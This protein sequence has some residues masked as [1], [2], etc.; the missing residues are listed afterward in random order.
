MLAERAAAPERCC[1][2]T[3]RGTGAAALWNALLGLRADSRLAH[4]SVVNELVQL[5]A[6]ADVVIAA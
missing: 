4:A 6:Q 2:A 3:P 5:I 1:E